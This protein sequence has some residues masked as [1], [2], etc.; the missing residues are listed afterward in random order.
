[1]TALPAPPAAGPQPNWGAVGNALGVLAQQVPLLPNA[2]NANPNN[3]AFQATNAML[4]NI[5]NA[6]GDIQNMVASLVNEVALQPMRTANAS[7]SNNA[8][9]VYPPGTAEGVLAQLPPSKRDAVAITG[10][11]AHQALTLL[12]VLPLHGA[13]TEQLRAQFCRFIGV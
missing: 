7:A 9:L 4:A 12:G 11:G 6:V 1:M 10:A 5:Q 3:T 13:N 8:P 2:V